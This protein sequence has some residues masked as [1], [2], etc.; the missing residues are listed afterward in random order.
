MSDDG[1]TSMLLFNNR[2]YDI[3]VKLDLHLI[4][5]MQYYNLYSSYIF[6]IESQSSFEMWSGRYYKD[7]KLYINHIPPRYKRHKHRFKLF[8]YA[9]DGMSLT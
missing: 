5:N 4:T 1:I 7:L 2:K 6:Y 3:V 8:V 9:L